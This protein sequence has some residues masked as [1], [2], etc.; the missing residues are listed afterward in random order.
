MLPSI[1]L[2]CKNLTFIHSRQVQTVPGHKRDPFSK[3]FKPNL[4]VSEKDNNNTVYKNNHY[5]IL[6]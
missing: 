6:I 2:K 4:R 1:V 5:T 3:C